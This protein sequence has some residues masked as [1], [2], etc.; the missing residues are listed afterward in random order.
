MLISIEQ[1]GVSGTQPESAFSVA[2]LEAYTIFMDAISLPSELERFAADA[3]ATGRY[4]SVTDVVAAALSLLRQ[5]DAELMSFIQSLVD[6]A[7]EGERDGFLS[8]DEV[9]REM[10]EM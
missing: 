9:H 4:T 8:A 7:A 6:A 5:S 2:W 3:V 1:G 10:T